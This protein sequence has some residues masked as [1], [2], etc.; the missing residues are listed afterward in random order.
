MIDQGTGGRA[1]ARRSVLLVDDDQD[2]AR[3][4]AAALEIAGYRVIKAGDGAAALRLLS[5][6]DCDLV[7]CEALL[8]DLDGLDICRAIKQAPAT[9]ETSVV[10]ILDGDDDV[11]REKAF[12]AGADD[13]CARPFDDATLLAIVRAQLRIRAL[14][15]QIYELEGAV[16]TLARSVE[17]RDHSSGGISE[18]VAYWAMQLG[19]A[20]GLGKEELTLLYKAALLHDVGSVAVPVAVLTKQAG[21]DP[22]EFNTV[23]R[24]PIVGEEILRALPGSDQLLPAIRHHHERIDGAG[25]PDGVIGESIPLFARIISVSDAFVAMTSDRPYRPRRTK[26]EAVRTLRQGAG[27]Q[28]DAALVDR[29]LELVA[30]ADAHE[31]R[32]GGAS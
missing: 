11:K 17:D 8:P 28:W 7:V 3:G 5:A 26:E 13:V 12:S 25:Y 9:R 27:K 10:L 19:E 20:W 23:K 30:G 1:D 15:L 4:P 24:H 29:F 21:L 18:K 31:A 6:H 22:S 16:L 32:V 2:R 14:R